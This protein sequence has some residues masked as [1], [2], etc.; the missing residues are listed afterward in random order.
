V[1]LTTSKAAGEL[2]VITS[3]AGS[4][5]A[6]RQHQYL[7]VIDEDRNVVL[8]RD[9]TW[10]CGK[11]RPNRPATDRTGNVFLRYNP[12]RYD[13]VIVLR[14]VGD[15]IVSFGTLPRGGSHYYGSGPVGYYA[16]TEDKAPHAATSRFVST[17]TTACRTARVARPPAGSSCGTDQGTC[18]KAAYASSSDQVSGG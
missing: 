15:R 9:W 3:K 1:T 17:A 18:A 11:I 10:G 13:G 16:Q 7:A 8:R 12:G 14:A 2:T 6:Y 5:D 4:C